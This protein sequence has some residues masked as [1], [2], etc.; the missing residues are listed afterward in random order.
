M[1]PLLAPRLDH[2][3]ES[4]A[5]GDTRLDGLSVALALIPDDTF[6]GELLNGK[7]IAV[8]MGVGF[9]LKTGCLQRLSG[10]PGL[11]RRAAFIGVDES[12]GNVEVLV[13]S[14]AEDITHCR[15]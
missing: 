13:K 10:H 12:D 14:Q 6:D 15:R 11:D 5:I 8:V 3:R 1:P 2:R 7:D 4:P 9:G